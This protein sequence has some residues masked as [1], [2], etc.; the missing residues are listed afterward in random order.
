[1]DVQLIHGFL[2]N[3]AYWSKGI[4][5]TTVEKSIKN[6]LNFGLFHHDKQ[7]GNARVISDFATIAYLGDVFVLP[8]HQNRGLSKALMHSVRTHPDLQGLRRWILLTADAHELYRQFGW[9]PI[10]QPEKW[11]EIHAKDIYR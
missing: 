11:M 8:D 1:M 6:S 7:V 10:H 5:L 2:C 3:E 9:Q 4:P